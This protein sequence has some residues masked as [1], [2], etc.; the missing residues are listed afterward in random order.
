MLKHS[1]ELDARLE[2][3]YAQVRLLLV[4]EDEASRT[5]LLLWFSVAINSV[6]EQAIID[7]SIS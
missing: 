2:H 7:A 4:D 3:L 6:I 5:H 1:E